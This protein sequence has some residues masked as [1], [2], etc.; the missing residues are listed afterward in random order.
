MVF[1]AL[2]YWGLSVASQQAKNFSESV[3]SSSSNSKLVDSQSTNPCAAKLGDEKPSGKRFIEQADISEGLDL[4]N[5][6]DADST[7]EF[8]EAKDM[9]TAAEKFLNT[10]GAHDWNQAYT[11]ITTEAKATPLATKVDNWSGEYGR[12]PTFSMSGLKKSASTEHASYGLE[13]CRND[14]SAGWAKDI[15]VGFYKTPSFEL[16]SEGKVTTVITIILKK[17]NGSWLVNG[18][19]NWEHNASGIVSGD[20]YSHDQNARQ[21][22][23]YTCS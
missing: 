19:N 9:K 15:N 11:L 13:M 1:G 3:N 16:S 17:E 10:L 4:H 12:W 2:A 7:L 14:Y 22:N 5:T 18:E 21:L 8:C 23:P 6:G 20:A